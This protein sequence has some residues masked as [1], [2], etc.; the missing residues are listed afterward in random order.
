M[1]N[2]FS[3]RIGMTYGVRSDYVR[4][5]IYIGWLTLHGENMELMWSCP[6]QA[7]Q[8]VM[9]SAQAKF[10]SFVWHLTAEKINMIE[11]IKDKE[12]WR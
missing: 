3:T 8:E 4:G 10:R 12:I 2:Y 6:T 1:S 11:L 5:D 9:R 7:T